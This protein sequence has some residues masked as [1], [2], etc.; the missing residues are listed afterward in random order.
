[1]ARATFSMSDRPPNPV[2]GDRARRRTHAERMGKDVGGPARGADGGE[3]LVA[4]CMTGTSI[5]GLDVALV[6]II[7]QGLGMRVELVSETTRPFGADTGDLAQRLRALADQQPMTARDIAQLARDFALLHLDA[8]KELAHGKHI[9]LVCVH[10]QTVFHAPPL[11]WQLIN[12]A[13][14]AHGLGV[15]VVSDLR[16]ADLAC[17][18]EGA[19][20]TPIADLVLFGHVRE[21]R[22]VVNLG[23]FCNLTRL[24]PG[25]EPNRVSG[26]DVCACNQVLDAVARARLRASY[27]RDGRAALAG[28][29][30]DAATEELVKLL[31][32]QA[33][34]GRSLGTGDE[35]TD[36]IERHA[37]LPPADAARSACAAIAT[38]IVEAAKPAERLIVAG[39]GV[40]NR[41]LMQEI[42]G[43]AGVPVD[44][45]DVHGVPASLRE[46]V[47]F[48][49]LGALSADRVAI[50]LPRVTGVDRAPIAG[51]WVWPG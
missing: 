26:G 22:T 24:D 29:A 6:K 36:W 10:G 13:P 23:G 1:M 5:D 8:L 2:E 41:A 44:T 28:T 37:E 11:S 40:R 34:A 38:V 20:I 30:D 7:G 47:A 18:G 51:S 49:V 25:R 39:G 48:A 42:M 31:R 27:D 46:A 21:R 43:R 19:P 45:S 15:P 33:K 35:L 12:P 14:I 3:R 16:A 4:G 50:T 32:A 9:D 17:G